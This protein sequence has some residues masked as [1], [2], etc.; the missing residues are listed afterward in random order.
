MQSLLAA[1]M[2]RPMSKVRGAST[3]AAMMAITV[4][5][6]ALADGVADGDATLLDPIEITAP[7]P[8]ID[9]ELWRLK[10]LLEATTPCLGCDADALPTRENILAGLV[11]FMFL[12]SEPPPMDEARLVLGTVR[13]AQAGPASEF[14]CP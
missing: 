5:G 2:L 10:L 3:A 9:A 8:A 7:V 6:I 1:P 12:A 14:R 11:R 4:T 13:C